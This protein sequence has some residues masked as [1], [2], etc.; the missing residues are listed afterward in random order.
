[1]MGKRGRNAVVERCN[2]KNEVRKL[3]SFYQRVL[4]R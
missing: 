2:N 3:L 1:M 4:G